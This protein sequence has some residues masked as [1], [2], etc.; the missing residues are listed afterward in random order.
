M[1]LTVACC[2]FPLPDHR[3]LTAIASHQI[4]LLGGRDTCE[5]HAL[6]DY[7]TAA[8]QFDSILSVRFNSHFPSEP[9]LAGVY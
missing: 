4:I 3:A 6:S 7:M 8:W 2:C 1:D 5:Q 9:A